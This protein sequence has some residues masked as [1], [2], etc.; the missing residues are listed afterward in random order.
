MSSLRQLLDTLAL[1]E[2]LLALPT[3]HPHREHLTEELALLFRNFWLISTASG[4]A[5]SAGKDTQL[6]RACLKSIA[7]KTPSL[8]H[9]TPLNYTETE[10]EYNPILRREHGTVRTENPIGYLQRWL[11]RF[12]P[13]HAVLRK[14]QGR[15]RSVPQ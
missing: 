14:P 10:L 8:L 15:T 1:I 5:S 2:A 7:A 9:G 6:H 4:L 12:P 11:T 3:F 13:C